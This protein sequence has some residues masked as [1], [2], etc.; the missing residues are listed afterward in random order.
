MG[1]S[2]HEGVDDR[3]YRKDTCKERR[4]GLRDGE[5]PSVVLEGLVECVVDRVDAVG[6]IDG[7]TCHYRDDDRDACKE[8]LSLFLLIEL[9]KVLLQPAQ[10]QDEHPGV[11]HKEDAEGGADEEELRVAPGSIDL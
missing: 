2:V 11:D 9:G 3:S 5:Q 4:D 10:E 7:H 6:D 8:D 1:Y